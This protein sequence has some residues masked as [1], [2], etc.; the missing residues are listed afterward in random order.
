MHLDIA[1][2]EAK[3]DEQGEQDHVHDLA[4][5]V[6]DLNKRLEDIRREQQYQRERE[7]EFRSLSDSTNSR[8][9][10]MSIIQIVVLFGTAAWQSRHLKVSPDLHTRRLML[11]RLARRSSLTRRRCVSPIWRQEQ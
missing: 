10:W 4:D 3:V 2:G 1:V 8:A 5:K 6:K 9:V 11:I 7:A